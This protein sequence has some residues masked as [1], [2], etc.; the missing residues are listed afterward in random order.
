MNHKD[1]RLSQAEDQEK[2]EPELRRALANFKSSVDAWSDSAM[3]RPREAK[4]PAQTNWGLITKWVLGCAVFAGTITG[5]V[6]QNY[7]QREMANAEA[8]RIA[9]QQ[10]ELAE[11]RLKAQEE[12]FIAGVDSDVAREV[13][14]ALE[15]L[16]LMTE[17]ENSDN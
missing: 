1:F 15:P 9:T 12:E 14:S 8:M 6:Y 16:A 11:Q 7:L 5:A 13:P 10:R 17:D 4:I 3:S 2:I